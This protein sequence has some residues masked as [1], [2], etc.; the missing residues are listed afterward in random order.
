LVIIVFVLIIWPAW[1]IRLQVRS[2]IKNVKAKIQTLETLRLKK[3]EWI[4]HKTDF[5]RYV[6]GVKQK[7]YISG[8]S[9]LLLGEISKLAKESAISIIAS[10]PQDAPVKF[11]VPYHQR[12]EAR[13]YDFVVEGGYHELGTFTSRIESYPKLLRIQKFQITPR[14]DKPTSH[15]AEIRLAV[16][17]MKNGV[18]Q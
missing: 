6:Q 18:A 3:S 2:Q 17:S 7:L 12:Y 14:D 13:Y 16:I 1:V 11:P 10:R 9:S 4:H 8:E 15:L 5:G